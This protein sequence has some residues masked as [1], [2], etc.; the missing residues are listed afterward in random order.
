MKGGGVEVTFWT[1]E[2]ERGLPKLNNFEQVGVAESTFSDK[3]VIKSETVMSWSSREKK[4]DIV[5]IVYCL[6]EIII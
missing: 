6:K 1:F 5:Y 2:N 4:E 3:T